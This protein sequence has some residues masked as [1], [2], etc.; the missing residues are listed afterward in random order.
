MSWQVNTPPW[1][2][3]RA[4]RYEDM[5]RYLLASFAIRY[6]DMGRYLLASFAIRYEDMGRCLLAS[7]MS[8]L[9]IGTES[10]TPMEEFNPK[11]DRERGGRT[12]P[13]CSSHR[14]S[15]RGQIRPEVSLGRRQASSKS[16]Q[17][18]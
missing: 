18:E 9:D 10:E 11:G 7:T 2:Q 14:I 5:G 4:I 17:S 6:E 3:R 8:R 12:K 15:H 1:V 16:R 13:K